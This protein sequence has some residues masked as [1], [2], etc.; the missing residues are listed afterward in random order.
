MYEVE[1]EKL[2]HQARGIAHINDK[3]VFVENSLPLEKVKIKIVKENKKIMEAVVIDY[4]EKSIDRIESPCPYYNECGGC[5]LLHLSY[6]QQLKYKENKIKEIMNR[7]ADIDESLIKKIVASPKHYNSRNKVTLKVKNKVGYYKKKSYDIVEIEKCLIAN[8]K[9]NQTIEEIKKIAIPSSINELVIRSINET[10]ISLTIY[11]QNKSNIDNF[12]NLLSKNIDSIKVTFQN[13]ITKEIGKSNIIGRLEKYN[14]QMSQNAFFQVNTQQ[15]INLYDKIKQYVRECNFPTT[16]DL[17]CGTGTIGIYVSEY[18][19]KVI[20]VEINSEAIENAKTNANNN[21]IKNIEFLAGD[22]KMILNRNNYD[23]DLVI[24]DPPRSGLDAEVINDIFKI[25]P[26]DIIYVSCDPIT[27]AR[28]LKLFKVKYEIV[29]ITPFDMFPNTYH[30]ECVV[31]LHINK[32][33]N[34]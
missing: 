1:I 13:N 9:I 29:E 25:N 31:R 11:L 32:S 20:G 26:S 6:E 18:A 4:I 5:D 21:N 8:E 34:S 3:I 16:L 30:V 14:Y 2:D 27:L 12:V 23:A 17:Y 10:D 7:Y 24:V 22:A 19:S 33:I 28:D 15:T